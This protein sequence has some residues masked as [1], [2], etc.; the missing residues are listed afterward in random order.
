MRVES[1]SLLVASSSRVGFPKDLREE[2]VHSF[3]MASIP[4]PSSCQPVDPDPLQHV[5][6]FQRFV[7]NDGGERHVWLQHGHGAGYWSPGA[8]TQ[9]GGIR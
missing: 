8:V 7:R 6:E 4:S 2:C 5:I 9:S 3:D 1:I